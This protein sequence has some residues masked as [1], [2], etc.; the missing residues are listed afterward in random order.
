MAGQRSGPVGVGIIGA[1]TISKTYLENLTSFPDVEVLAIGD[2]I[3]DAAK[4]KAEEFNIPASGGPDAVLGHD[5]VEMVVNLTIPAV[6]AEVAI[7][8]LE[9]GKHVFNEKP[10]SLDRVSAKALLDA[11]E[12]AGLRVGCAPDT[13]LGSGLQ[14]ARKIIDRGD[15]GTPLS[16]LTLMQSPGPESWHPN[17][18]FL[19]Q[20]GAGPLFDIGPYYFTALV[21]LFGA[22]ERVGAVGSKSREQRVIGSGPRAGES[23]DVTVPT[24][25][26]AAA[27]FSGGQSSQTILSFDSAVRRILFEVNGTEGTLAVPDPNMF[28]GEIKVIRRTDDDWET[29]ATTSAQST[30]GTGALDLARAIREDRPHRASGA[31][32]YHV[33]DVME[34]VSE[35]ATSGSYVDVQS[36]VERPELLPE[37]WDP[38]AKTL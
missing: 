5:G 13:F 30:R 26:S 22:V 12:K 35:A 33:L 7:S 25:I 32:A 21:Q 24:H 18:A 4:A 34:A 23:F 17:P 36:R 28:D 10:L 37:D 27:R 20:E 38:K 15:I 8:A 2:I 9:A 16:A 14:E 3:T 29:V 19:F 31:Q 11:A 1:G 6:H